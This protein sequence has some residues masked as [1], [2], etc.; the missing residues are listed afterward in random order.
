MYSMNINV[1]TQNT[2]DKNKYIYD[3]NNLFYIDNHLPTKTYKVVKVNYTLFNHLEY[4]E[5]I[6][7][8]NTFHAAFQYA[9]IN[10]T[11]TNVPKIIIMID[12]TMLKLST[13]VNAA[14]MYSIHLINVLKYVNKMFNDNIHKCIIINYNE[15]E[16]NL[17]LLFKIF[18]KNIDFIQKI[19]LH[20]PV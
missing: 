10:N 19:Q 5:I 15:F 2:T 8:I 12:I 13:E 9:F 20:S 17:I 4:L 14:N 16:K 7:I 3:S 11:I 18:F 6:S 1:L